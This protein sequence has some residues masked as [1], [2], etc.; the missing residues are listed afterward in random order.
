MDPR[1]SRHGIKQRIGKVPA[2]SIFPAGSLR[3]A[4]RPLVMQFPGAQILPFHFRSIP[5][6][7]PTIAA[8]SSAWYGLA[9]WRVPDDTGQQLALTGYRLELSATNPTPDV[10]TDYTVAGNVAAWGTTF[11]TGAAIVVGLNLPVKQGVWGSGPATI[12]Y[13]E[14]TTVRSAFEKPNERF[15][16]HFAPGKISDNPQPAVYRTNQTTPL[17]VLLPNGARLDVALVVRRSQINGVTKTDGI[18]G[19][20]Y[21]E[22]LVASMLTRGDFIE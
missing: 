20:C 18:I 5:L 22:L 8:G 12:P 16:F 19:R 2:R 15:V 13:V 10:D 4:E 17:A 7:N 11:G 1:L 3:G 6:A 14:A 21:G 9:S